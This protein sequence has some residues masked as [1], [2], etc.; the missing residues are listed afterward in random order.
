MSESIAAR[1]TAAAEATAEAAERAGRKPEEVTVVA[2]SKTFGADDAA[3]AVA[4][5]ATDLGESRAQE[6]RDKSRLLRSG[7]RWHF[8]GPLQTNKVRLVV[9]AALIHSVD[10]I[11]LAQSIARRAERSGLVQGVLLQVNVAGQEHQ[12]GVV[13]GG[14]ES[15]AQEAVQLDGI[16]VRGLMTIPP[17][18]DDPNGVRACYRTLAELSTP[19]ARICPGAHELSMGMSSDFQI[20]IEEGAT[21]VRLGRAIFGARS[22]R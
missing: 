7:V 3:A 19:L 18:G 5:G 13:P 14:L 2:V 10:K 9:G 21:I 4:A 17:N 20:A 1:W 11:E 12:R 8:V 15:L 22:T 6:L 16:E